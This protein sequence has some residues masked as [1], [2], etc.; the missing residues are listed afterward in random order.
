MTREMFQQLRVLTTSL[1]TWVLFCA[2]IS[3][4]SQL[5]ISALGDLMFLS[6]WNCLQLRI[7][8]H[9]QTQTHTLTM[10]LI[11]YKAIPS[12]SSD[13]SFKVPYMSV[14]FLSGYY[15][16]SMFSSLPKISVFVL[17]W[18]I[19]LNNKNHSKIEWRFGCVIN[20]QIELIILGKIILVE[21]P[22]VI[23]SLG[24]RVPAGPVE[25]ERIQEVYPSCGEEIGLWDQTGG[26]GLQC[27]RGSWSWETLQHQLLMSSLKAKLL[28]TE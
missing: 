15:S 9:Q 10:L 27:G 13:R 24:G 18:K 3:D 28:H 19:L 11:L 4:G 2:P 12:C 23:E 6:F 21:K 8:T 7:S 25:K 1:V 22:T 26:T 14:A 17:L 20:R 16:W 5:I